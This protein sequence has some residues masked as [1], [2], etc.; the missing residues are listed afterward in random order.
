MLIWCNKQQKKAP[1]KSV[2]AEN[3]EVEESAEAEEDIDV[4]DE[5]AELPEVDVTSSVVRRTKKAKS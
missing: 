3:Y 2:E 1:V 5:V 4:T